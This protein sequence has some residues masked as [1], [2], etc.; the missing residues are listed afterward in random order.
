VVFGAGKLAAFSVYC[1]EC[2]TKRL[3]LNLAVKLPYMR[4]TNAMVLGHDHDPEL[5][6]QDLDALG[7]DELHTMRTTEQVAMHT[8]YPK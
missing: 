3:G 7:R 6:A 5:A 1:K 8:T 2:L 4:G